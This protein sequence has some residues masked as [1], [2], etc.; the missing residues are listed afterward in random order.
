MEEIRAREHRQTILESEELDSN[1]QNLIS[2]LIGLQDQMHKMNERIECLTQSEQRN[3]LGVSH[4]QSDWTEG[5][6]IAAAGIKSGG[7]GHKIRPYSYQVDSNF[8]DNADY[9]L[10]PLAGRE[11]V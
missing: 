5:K 7:E 4:A 11:S 8:Q 9:E 2:I 1:Y 6:K 3:P 10:P